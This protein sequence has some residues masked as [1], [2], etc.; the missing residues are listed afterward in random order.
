MRKLILYFILCLSWS[1]AWAQE[2]I[3]QFK[4][5]SKSELT[6]ISELVSIDNYENGK[7]TAYANAEQLEQFK[8]LAYKYK[9]LPHPSA[10]KTITMAATT[11]EMTNWDRYPTYDVYL[12]MMNQFE[13]DYPDLCQTVN[14]GT[15]VNGR[16]LLAVKI[17]DNVNTHEA[18]PEFFYTSTMHGDET[19]GFVLLLRLT[20]WLLSN[21]ETDEQAAYIIDNFELYINPNA[22]P[23]GTYTN[24]NST[25]SGATRYNSAGKDL[26][27]NFPD[28]R[29]GDPE[30]SENSSYY[31]IQPETQAMMDF[32]ESH[33]FVM[34]AN[35]HG[36]IELAN[37]P[38]DTWTENYPDYRPHA[39]RDWWYKVAGDYRDS[40]QSNSPNGYF[41]DYGGLTN[42]GDWYVITGG[43]QDYMNYFQHCRELTLEISY[44]KMPSSDELP[45]YWNY[46][47]EALMNYINEAG[48]G[49]FGTVTDSQGNPFH[50]KIEIPEHDQD[51]SQVFTDADNGDYYRPLA[52]GTYDVKF[53]A[54]GYISQ[55]LTV[56]ISDWKTRTE[57][58]VILE[59]DNTSRRSHARKKKMHISPNPASGQLKITNSSKSE[60][61]SVNIC[62][63]SGK[64]IIQKQSGFQNIQFSLPAGFYI[65][66][67][68]TADQEFTEKLIVRK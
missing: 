14:I 20:D 9:V 16:Q 44:P 22:N 63:T 53:S 21:Y 19:A 38:W 18:E 6:K 45:Y 3:I 10:G 5:E 2:T 66:K 15:S 4:I 46:N 68:K 60:I 33:N 50:A 27:R 51:S 64:E 65:V 30:N 11:A 57:K 39:D 40:A 43:R 61:K 37:Y 59:A 58:N 31:P 12:D 54:A 42:G 36:G 49:L 13:T 35:L 48:Y 28:P 52:P 23:D 17:S 26:N 67:I 55:T 25:I 47:F 34:S 1:V 7:V 32:A 41:D 62:T 56:N 8:K 29:I 24:D